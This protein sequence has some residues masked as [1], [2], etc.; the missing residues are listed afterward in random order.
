MLVIS[1]E[2]K[3]SIDSLSREEILQLDKLVV[4]AKVLEKAEIEAKLTNLKD[5]ITSEGIFKDPK[6]K[7][8]IFTEH[9]DTL[10]YLVEKLEEWGLAVTKIHGGMKI[11]NRNTSGTRLYA[12]RAFRES[13][14]KASP[15]G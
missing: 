8:L 12:E 3:I 6:M 10:D 15:P 13:M 14:K 2:S 1:Q 7:L 11:G 9:K 5:V 4:Q